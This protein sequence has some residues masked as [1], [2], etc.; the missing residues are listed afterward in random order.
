MLYTHGRLLFLLPRSVQVGV[1]Q[2]VTHPKLVVSVSV[3]QSQSGVQGKVERE[4]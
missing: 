1:N 2:G 3:L 4:H